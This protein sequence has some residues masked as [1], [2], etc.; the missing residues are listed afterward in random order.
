MYVLTVDDYKNIEVY[1]Y[2]ARSY[3][4]FEGNIIDFVR[5]NYGMFY[6]LAGK[7]PNL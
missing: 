3:V 6:N 5:A 7:T 2:D 4:E 1:D